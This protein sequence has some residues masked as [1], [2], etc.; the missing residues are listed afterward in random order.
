MT[1]VWDD[2][3]F[4]ELLISTCSVFRR[5]AAS[6]SVNYGQKTNALPTTVATGVPCKYS[7]G[8]GTEWKYDKKMVLSNGK[9]Y[10]RVPTGFTLTEKDWLEIDGVTGTKFNILNI[11]NPGLQDHHLEISV[12]QVKP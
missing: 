2:N 9:V 6:S 5:A 1:Q 11:D 10:M 12:Q 3:E 7:R 8:G 4:D